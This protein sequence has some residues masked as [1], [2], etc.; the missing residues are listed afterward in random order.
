MIP[1]IRQRAIVGE[2]GK[3]EIRSPELPPSAVVE[4]IVMIEPA[5]G[6]TTE[7]LLSSE[8]NR[9]RLMESLED[10]KDRSRYRFPA[11]ATL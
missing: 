3:I 10:L 8:A 1:G 5:E 7:C 2:G 4:V 11:S 6:D 9:K